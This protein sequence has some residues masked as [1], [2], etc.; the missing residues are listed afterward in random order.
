M[1]GCGHM[2]HNCENALSATVS[3]YSKLIAFV[4]RIVMLLSYAIVDFLIL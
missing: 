1:L 3:I 4:L 2:S